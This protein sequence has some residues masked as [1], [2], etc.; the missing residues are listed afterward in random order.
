M[1]TT[2]YATFRYDTVEVQNG[3]NCVSQSQ[4]CCNLHSQFMQMLL[5]E[6]SILTDYAIK[7]PIG[8]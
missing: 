6:E 1:D 8:F 7:S 5:Y 3:L 4:S 2:E